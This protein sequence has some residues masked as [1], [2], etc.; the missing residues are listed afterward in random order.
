MG[1]DGV[2]HIQ[3][4]SQP[5]THCDDAARCALQPQVASQIGISIPS[6]AS[7]VLGNRS[8]HNFSMRT[9]GKGSRKH[10]GALLLGAYRG[11]KLR[12]FGHSGTGF[13]ENGLADTIERFKPR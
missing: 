9:E 1:N 11:G 2:A 13:T 5:T 4:I 12:Y 10:L 8:R 7:A 3:P 6:R